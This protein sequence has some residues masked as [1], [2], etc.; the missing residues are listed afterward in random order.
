MSFGYICSGTPLTRPSTGRRSV[1]HVSGAGVVAL[2]DLIAL[3][4]LNVSCISF[5]NV[6]IALRIYLSMAISNCSREWSCSKIKSI[7]YEVRSCMDQ[8]RLSFLSLMSIENDIVETLTVACRE[9]GERGDVPSVVTRGDI[10]PGRSVLGAPNW[11]QY[12]K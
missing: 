12:V 1:G 6:H 4:F 11:G 8:Q 5:P 7:K 9:K 10:C 2:V 3:A